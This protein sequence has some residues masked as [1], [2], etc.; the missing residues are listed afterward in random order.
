[1]TV[2]SERRY[3]T[4][5][6]LTNVWIRHLGSEYLTLW[7]TEDWLKYKDYALCIN[8]QKNSLLYVTVTILGEQFRLHRLLIKCE[9]KDLVDHIDGD[10]LNNCKHNLRLATNAENMQNRTNNANSNSTSGVRGVGFKSQTGTWTAQVKIDGK[11]KHL[12]TFKTVEEAE[13]IVIEYRSKHM[14]FSKE[15]RL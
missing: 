15:A 14:L 1:M 9:P 8:P 12:G 3:E 2:R 6:I 7:D 10:G 11:K 13:K 5:G 4:I